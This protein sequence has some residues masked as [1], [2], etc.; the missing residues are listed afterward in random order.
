MGMNEE[1]DKILKEGRKI[2][3]NLTG[4]NEVDSIDK[5]LEIMLKPVEL[6]NMKL[7]YERIEENLDPI[8]NTIEAEVKFKVFKAFLGKGQKPILIITKPYQMIL[9]NSKLVLKPLKKEDLR[10]FTDEKLI[11]FFLEYLRIKVR[12]LKKLR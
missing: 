10:N 7:I 1:F 11:R 12:K 2:K 6:K 8:F 9:S 4:L 5:I 3:Y